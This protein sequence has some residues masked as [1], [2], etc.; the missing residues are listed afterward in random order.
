VVPPLL[1]KCGI[2]VA[3]IEAS[4]TFIVLGVKGGYSPT[5]VQIWPM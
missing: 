5:C 4:N 2:L 3:F 1:P